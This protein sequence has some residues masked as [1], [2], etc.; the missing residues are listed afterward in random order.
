MVASKVFTQETVPDQPFPLAVVASDVMG[1]SLNT[2]ARKILGDFSFTPMGAISIGQYSAGVSGDIRLSPTGIVGRNSSNV[3]TFYINATTGDAMFRGT[4]HALAGDIGGFTIQLS[5]LYAGS[6]ANTAGMSP[7][8]YPFWA[9]ATYANRATA[10]FR[11]TPTGSLYASSAFISGDIELSNSGD[12]GTG[13]KLRWVGGTRIWSDSSNRMGIN[14]IGSPMY[15]YVNSTEKIVIPQSGQ[16]SMRNGIYC[17][18]NFNVEGDTRFRYNVYIDY[19]NIGFGDGSDNS[20]GSKLFTLRDMGI[21]ISHSGGGYVEIKFG[22]NTYLQ[23][24]DGTTFK[25]F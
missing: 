2:K 9:G 14:S 4:L 23:I 8:D 25:N 16:T 1:G 19:D 3:Q 13:T 6:G 7:A 15:I 21:T 17:D 22:N 10:P 12:E 5:Y 24:Q 11:I 18:G 20:G